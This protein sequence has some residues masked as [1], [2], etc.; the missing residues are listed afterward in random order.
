LATRNFRRLSQPPRWLPL[1][2][3]GAFGQLSSGN[4]RFDR[5]FNAFWRARG[6][7]E[8]QL[9]NVHAIGLDRLA[10]RLERPID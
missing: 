2:V 4:F 3:L 10:E 9:Q 8:T 1:F 6:R 5:L 7:R